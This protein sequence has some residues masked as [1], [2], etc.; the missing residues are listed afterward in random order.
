MPDPPERVIP[1]DPFG[2]VYEHPL[3]V[4]IFT[5][6]SPIFAFI[7]AIWATARVGLTPIRAPP[8]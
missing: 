8:R 2:D 4:S 1:A 7:C 3:D 5:G 6:Y